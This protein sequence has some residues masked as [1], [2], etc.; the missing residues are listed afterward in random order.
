M[1]NICCLCPTYR[2]APSSA[3]GQFAVRHGWMRRDVPRDGRVRTVRGTVATSSLQKHLQKQR[4]A[5]A[6]LQ[7]RFPF[8]IQPPA[9]VQRDRRPERPRPC[10]RAGCGRPGCLANRGGSC[11]TWGHTRPWPFLQMAFKLSSFKDNEVATSFVKIGSWGR[12]RWV[13]DPSRRWR[14]RGEQ[15]CPPATGTFGVLSI[16]TRVSGA[17]SYNCSDA[18]GTALST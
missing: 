1:E 11:S 17:P 10:S 6:Q 8:Q 3:E 18:H 14:H 4:F 16:R 13:F 7:P 2:S 5:K 15:P 9:R 12:L